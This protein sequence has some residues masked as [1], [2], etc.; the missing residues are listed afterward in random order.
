[1]GP[2][3]AASPPARSNADIWAFCR[4]GWRPSPEGQQV[5]ATTSRQRNDDTSAAIAGSSKTATSAS[6]APRP[7]SPSPAP[8]AEAHH[9]QPSA[10][11]SPGA[12][13]PSGAGGL[14]P[15]RFVC[16]AS[17]ALRA[18]LS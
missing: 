11:H 17:C 10:P 15:L 14:T 9:P 18:R 12:R 3:N 16:R 4:K 6:K 2:A 7:S 8:H 5:A 1:M 13:P